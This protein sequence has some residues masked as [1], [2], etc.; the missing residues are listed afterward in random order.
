[1]A[2]VSIITPVKADD[3]K[4]VQWL[5]EAMESVLAQTE[6]DWE[7][8]VIND[9]S[10]VPLS[11]VKDLFLMD[12]RIRGAGAQRI[13]V[14]HARNQGAKMAKS[15]LI[16]PL[17]ADDILPK[18][19]VEEFLRAWDQG[20]SRQGI[21]Y[22][23][24]V[25]ITEDAQRNYQSSPYSFDD[26]LQKLLMPVGSL[27]RK[28]DWQ[29]SGGWKP[30]MEFGLEDW[31]YWI[32][33]G[34]LGVC[35]YHVA[36]PLYHYRRHPGG[37]LEYLRNTNGAYN[38]AQQTMRSIHQETYNGR[39]PMGCCGGAGAGAGQRQV[40]TGQQRTTA[41]AMRATLA[42]TPSEGLVP[43]MYTGGAQDFYV[44]GKVTGISYQVGSYGMM[45]RMPDSRYGVHPDDVKFI[46][47]LD[48]G[49][50]FAQR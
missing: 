18:N 47:S 14:A 39:K 37:R 46:L 22:S 24:T 6:P 40:R 28:S 30:E 9:H 5:R 16:L 31:E 45:L 20:G 41:Q 29:K 8:I 49:T 27:H 19:S 25:F 26:L 32:T 34:E 3:K 35:G 4:D 15:P 13:G 50:S 7:M 23:D 10:P 21:V 2:K 38:Q 43:I 33:L 48:R 36:L 11:N 12:N 42:N 17:D 1:M 44:R